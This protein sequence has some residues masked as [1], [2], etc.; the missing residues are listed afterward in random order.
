MIGKMWAASPVCVF[1]GRKSGGG[2]L[3]SKGPQAT[4]APSAF[5]QAFI[6]ALPRAIEHVS[7]A[8]PLAIDILLIVPS[9]DQKENSSTNGQAN[10]DFDEVLLHEVADDGVFGAFHK[11][12]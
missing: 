3:P 8:T 7:H 10:E 9:E 11:E 2:P 5:F 4:E 1:G 6:I 12:Y